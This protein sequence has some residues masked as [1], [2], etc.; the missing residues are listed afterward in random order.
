MHV[1]DAKPPS[2]AFE[3]PVEEADF[4]ATQELLRHPRPSRQKLAVLVLSLAAFSAV[5]LL[6]GDGS[7]VDLV[8]VAGVLLIH[9]LGHAIGMRAFGYRDVSMFFIPLFGAAASC[10]RAEPL[11]SSSS[12]ATTGSVTSS[13]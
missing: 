12:R 5:W 13:R 1:E 6:R 7:L 11:A 3:D 4:R 9:E 10:R 8:I 2:M